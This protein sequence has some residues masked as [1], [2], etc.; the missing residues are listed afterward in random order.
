MTADAFFEALDCIEEA[1]Y[2][3]DYTHSFKK[4]VRSCSKSKFDLNLLL[5][6][7]I[8]LVQN[9]YLDQTYYPHPLKGFPHKKN[10]KVMECHI[11]PDWLLVWAQYDFDLKLI[12][13]DTGT[14][15]DLF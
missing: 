9:G 3:L 6:A 12:L 13:L 5:V 7:V 8:F 2:N 4:S 1:K 11:S 14:H 10:R 15:S